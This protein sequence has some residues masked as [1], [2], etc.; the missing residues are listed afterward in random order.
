MNMHLTNGNSFFEEKSGL[1]EKMLW[2]TCIF[3]EHTTA[4]LKVMHIMN[5]EIGQHNYLCLKN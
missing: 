5:A 3:T 2:V 4:N 1:L